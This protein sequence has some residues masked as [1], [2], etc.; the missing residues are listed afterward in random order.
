MFYFAYG[1]NLDWAQMRGRCPSAKFVAIAELRKHRL[2]FTR[3]SDR[4]GYGV[5]DVFADD[6]K[7]V[8]GVVYDVAETDIGLLDKDEGYRP[9]RDRA[10]NSYVREQRHVLRDG[11]EEHPLLVW[12]YVGNPQP[13]PP[14]PNADYK[15]LLVEGADYWHLPNEYIEELKQIEVAK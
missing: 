4:R 13:N 3:K 12:L 5:S 14:L 7:S 11:D 8:W 15:T 6:T 1:S 2:K 9:G 10:A